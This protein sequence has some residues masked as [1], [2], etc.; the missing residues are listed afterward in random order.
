M[1]CVCARLPPSQFL[2]FKARKRAITRL[3]FAYLQLVG[4]ASHRVVMSIVY[5]GRQFY[6]QMQAHLMFS[7]KECVLFIIKGRRWGICDGP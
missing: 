3:T 7:H 4:L 1:S 5:L 6:L 2:L